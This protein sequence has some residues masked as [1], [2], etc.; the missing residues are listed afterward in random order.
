MNR[1]RWHAVIWSVLVLLAYGGYLI[2]PTWDG[3]IT[4]HQDLAQGTPR[5]M[6]Y[7]ELAP[8]EDE[9]NRELAEQHGLTAHR[10]AFCVV[11]ARDVQYAD[12]YNSVVCAELGLS[13]QIF[14]HIVH[15]LMQQH[16]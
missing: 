5:F 9:A 12:A 8:Y 4:A 3:Q 15:R 1:R 13:L 6:V 14:D 11:A 16:R 7:G 2:W 10:V